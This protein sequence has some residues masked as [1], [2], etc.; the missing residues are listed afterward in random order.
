MAT[1]T[2]KYLSLADFARRLDPDGKPAVIAELLSQENEILEDAIWQ[3]ANG[4]TGH[5]STI[6]TGL[7][8]LTWRLLNQGVPPS[9]STTA[10]VIDTFGSLTGYSVIDKKEAQLSGDVERF[11]LTEDVAFM[12]AMSQTI[13]STFFY[14]NTAVNQQQFLGFSPRFSTVSTANA[15]NAVNVLDAG[16]TASVNTS[17][18]LIGW[19]PRTV[20][21]IFPKG[22]KAGLTHIDHG[23][24]R[25]W[26]DSNGNPYETYQ[27]Y[28][29]WD[30]GL[31]VKDWRYVVRIANIDTTLLAG[32]SAA[33]LISLLNKAVYRPPTM[34]KGVAA[35]QKTDAP[36]EEIPPVRWAFY[37]N[38]TIRQYLDLQA[39]N[40]TNL[41]LRLSE[42]DGKVITDYRGIPIRTCDGLVNNETRVV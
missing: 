29:E 7:P 28:F 40:K 16:G 42:W 20:F 38:R 19:G 32:G 4:T 27:S 17:L 37:G 21:G 10:Q 26:V 1:L 22:S 25:S 9:K 24:T 15:Q 39:Q 3:E 12:E 13:A 8:A 33:N 5:Q 30:A 2:N 34:P 23:D 14:G 31:V 41:L 11:R 18:W 36:E 35:V 6:R